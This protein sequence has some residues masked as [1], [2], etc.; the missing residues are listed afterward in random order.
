MTD[1]QIHDKKQRRKKWRDSR[2]VKG[3]GETKGSREGSVG[4]RVNV[5]NV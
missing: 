3:T 2:R 1:R 5:A 4:G